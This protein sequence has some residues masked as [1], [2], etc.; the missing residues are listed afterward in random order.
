VKLG[1]RPQ[2]VTVSGRS[3]PCEFSA[4]ALIFASSDF[5]NSPSHLFVPTVLGR[6]G[7]AKKQA[8]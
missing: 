3:S 5:V 7:R 6:N 2:T 8:G 4:L 1:L